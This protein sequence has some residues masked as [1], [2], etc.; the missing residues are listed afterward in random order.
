MKTLASL[1]FAMIEKSSCTALEAAGESGR[2]LPGFV[3]GKAGQFRINQTI[4]EFRS[5]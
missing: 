3:A 2:A 4:A 1:A 5:K